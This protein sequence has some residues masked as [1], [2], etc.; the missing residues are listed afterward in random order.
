MK[1]QTRKLQ[2]I[3]KNVPHA[4]MDELLTYRTKNSRG[5]IRF[6]YREP[7]KGKKYSW[8]GALKR[9]DSKSADMYVDLPFDDSNHGQ[10]LQVKINNQRTELESLW[11]KQNNHDQEITNLKSQQTSNNNTIARQVGKIEDLKKA[12]WEVMKDCD[13]WKATAEGEIAERERVEEVSDSMQIQMRE[14]KAAE[15]IQYKQLEQANTQIADLKAIIIKITEAQ[16][17]MAKYL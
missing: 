2:S 8:G 10:F 12:K 3:L 9:E 14:Y 17:F 4:L 11:V 5:K 1:K 13:G 15:E 16:A 7:K 6:K